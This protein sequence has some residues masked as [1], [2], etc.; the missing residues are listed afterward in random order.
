MSG[1]GDFDGFKIDINISYLFD[2]QYPAKFFH[3]W[4]I[5]ASIEGSCFCHY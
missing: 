1:P 4:V 5:C 3:E 2:E